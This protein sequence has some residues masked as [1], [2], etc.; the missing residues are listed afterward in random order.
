M[1]KFLLLLTVSLGIGP[2]AWGQEA[3]VADSVPEAMVSSLPEALEETTNGNDDQVVL[4]PSLHLTDSL[5]IDTAMV[6]NPQWEFQKRPKHYLLAAAE[7][8]GCNLFFHVCTR[9][10]TDHDY[11]HISWSSIKNNFKKGFYWDNDKFETNLYSH[12]Y[13]GSLYYNCARTSGLNFW[14]S[15]PYALFGSSIWEMFMETQPPSTNDIIATPL[16]GIALGEIGYRISSLAINNQATGVERVGREAVAFLFNPIRGVKR[17]I[18]GDMWH[19][20]APRFEDEMAQVPFHMQFGVGYQMLHNSDLDKSSHLATADF[21]FVYNNPFA[22]TGKVPFEFFVLRTSL[23]F[24]KNQPALGTV[25]VRATLWGKNWDNKSGSEALFGIFQHFNYYNT[26][27]LQEEDIDVP[28][29][30]AETVSYGPGFIYRAPTRWK[31]HVFIMD[32]HLGAIILGGSLSNHY[33]FQERD[34]DLGSGYSIHSDFM[35]SFSRRVGV[36]ASFDHYRLFTWKGY[37]DKDYENPD[38]DLNYLNAMGARGNTWMHTARLR[39]A[40][41]LYK[42]LSLTAEG[43]LMQRRSHYKY[44]DDVKSNSLGF[45]LML[46]YFI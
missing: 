19:T 35:W 22:I 7:V 39:C 9:Y 30:I 18:S 44:Y 15:A 27:A 33:N 13:Q 26:E 14:E 36:A 1:K 11:A 31:D 42:G 4:E 37:E 24:G 3:I 23:N 12:P 16:G 38:F 40:L 8:V 32:M 34:Y 43:L 2:A 28:F 45:R 10:I 20:R 6:A 29:R 25:N 5:V 17:L 21:A 46:S 41:S